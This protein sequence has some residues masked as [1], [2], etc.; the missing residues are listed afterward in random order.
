MIL[1]EIQTI[2]HK[3]WLLMHEVISFLAKEFDTYFIFVTATEPL[4]F[5]RHEIKSLVNKDKYF[6]SLNRVKIKTSIENTKTLKEFAD[7]TIPEVIKSEKSFLFIFN[8][9]DSAKEFYKLLK[10]NNLEQREMTYLSTH[11]IP[12]E[13]LERIKIISNKEKRVVISTQLVEAGVDID[14]D[15]VYRD[16]APLDSINQSA[17][18]CN[19]NG[20]LPSG[21]VRVVNLFDEKTGRS[22]SSYI[23]N[24]NSILLHITKKILADK[25]EIRES[26]FIKLINEYY[27]NIVEA[28]SDEK[29]RGFL[30]AINKLNYDG[31][32]G[33]TS[34]NLIDQGYE[35][36]DIYVQYDDEAI[37]LW[38]KF[39]N[40]KNIQN[41]FERKKEFSKIKTQFHQY[42]I[43][44]P[45]K[46]NLNL[47][48][49]YENIPFVSHSQIEEYYDNETGYK[50]KGGVA[51]W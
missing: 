4:I 48:A 17:G 46:D 28:K 43:S 16:L 5:Q 7:E 22:Y 39:L 18:R 21:E 40:I 37:T 31:D 11:V 34:F 26:E 14:F 23:Y 19:R 25:N 38:D 2:P 32:N 24:E 13:R 12:K 15:V 50:L 20:L 51:V 36:V 33:I 41:L 3:Y 27:K 1:D 44:V 45:Y 30:Q 29:S 42:V 35:K 6:K 49:I 47:P 9:I 8:T 10:E